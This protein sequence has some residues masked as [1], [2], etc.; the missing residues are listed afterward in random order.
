MRLSAE[1]HQRIEAFFREHAGDAGLILPPIKIHAGWFAN[2]LTRLIG[3]NGITFGRH[4]F[5]RSWLVGSDARGRAT[6]DA[7]LLVHE[8]AHV[9]QYERG[10]YARFFRSYLRDYWRALRA[11]GRWDWDGRNAAYLAIAE[12]CEARAAEIAY[13]EFSRAGGCGGGEKVDVGLR[14]GVDE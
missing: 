5:I 1:T 2:L 10:G 11:G 14:D 12:E 13:R 7:L 4:V 6:I 8:A 3:I 9:L